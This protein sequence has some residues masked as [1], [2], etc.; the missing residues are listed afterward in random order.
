LVCPG[1]ADLHHL[2]DGHHHRSHSWHLQKEAGIGTL[3]AGV[4]VPGNT[5]R[6]S[7]FALWPDF[8][9]I[10]ELGGCKNHS[11]AIRGIGLVTTKYSLIL[12]TKHMFYLIQLW[13]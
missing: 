11:A 4:Y 9:H 6:W 3:L 8:G 7:Y 1:G 13:K 5:F 2:L 12:F 10:C